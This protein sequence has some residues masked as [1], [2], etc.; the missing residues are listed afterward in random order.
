MKAI[1]KK[2]LA[3][4][5]VLAMLVTLIPARQ[6]YAAD[7][8]SKIADK[9]YLL[10]TDIDS[11]TG[12]FTIV[13]HSVSETFKSVVVYS[14]PDHKAVDNFNSVVYG[15]KD[16]TYDVDVSDYTV[17]PYDVVGELSDGTKLDLSLYVYGNLL[18]AP[19]VSIITDTPKIERNTNFFSTGYNYINFCP[20]FTVHSDSGY[21]WLRLYD[22]TTKE[23]G[24]LYGP[25]DSYETLYTD[26]FKGNKKDGG[27]K[28]KANHTYKAK[29]CYAKEVTWNGSTY[30]LYGP[31]S[32]EV[33]LKTGKSGQPPIKSVKIKATKVKK[34]KLITHAHW[35]ASGKW[36]PYSEDYIWTT[37]IKVTVKMKK[38]PGTKGLLIGDKK[39]KGNKKTYTASF[40]QS[41]KLKGKKFTISICTYNDAKVN[42]Y[43]KIVKKK[44]KVS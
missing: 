30:Y 43:G 5:L 24:D 3:A 18:K 34:T 39:V 32:N 31:D 11:S 10:K 9:N 1:S 37:T 12:D 16:F 35:N 29:V 40:Q 41:G 42:G 7:D 27:T 6:T 26:Y 13:G 19:L 25:F 28:I 33:T 36:I 38:K 15:K 8:L 14:S 17:G 23:W 4:V 2:V 22:T 44:V 21:I 20:Y